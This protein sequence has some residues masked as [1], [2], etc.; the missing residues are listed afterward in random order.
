MEIRTSIIEDFPF[1]EETNDNYY[2]IKP[3]VLKAL[4]RN[5]GCLTASCDGAVVGV[6]V[7]NIGISP[8]GCESVYKVVLLVADSTET[9]KV[10]LCRIK[11][12]F[13]V[14]AAA[15]MVMDYVKLEYN[16]YLQGDWFELKKVSVE[17]PTKEKARKEVASKLYYC[18][19][20]MKLLELLDQY[21]E[22]TKSGVTDVAKFYTEEQKA[23]VESIENSL[24][25]YGNGVYSFP[26]FSSAFVHRLNSYEGGVEYKP[27]DDEAYA[28]QI[29]EI[30]LQEHN[31]ELFDVC[32]K[33]FA[34][35]VV[36][37][38]KILYSYDVERVSSIQFAKYDSASDITGG[39]WHYDED[40]EVTITVN[41]SD[42]EFEC[43]GTMIKPNGSLDPIVVPPVPVGHAML[44]RGKRF[45]HKGL[46]VTKGTRKLLVF[47][48]V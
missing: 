46:P 12:L 11:E 44:F 35:S 5:G 36:P 47:W 17:M 38:A 40:S 22:A 14:V 16:K 26:M 25:D 8:S 15:R 18:E 42:S 39:N 9:S 29:P 31:P 10:L 32:K 48:T 13:H 1:I 30:V 27:N 4:I 34:L 19:E 2:N 45:N 28:V 3:E 43:E 33:M 37:L 7:G 21:E 23:L 20:H 6:V 41:V 24:V